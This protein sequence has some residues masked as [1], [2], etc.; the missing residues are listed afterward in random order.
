MFERD[1]ENS[2]EVVLKS[3]KLRSVE[4]RRTPR[5]EEWRTRGRSTRRA[6]AAGAIRMGRTLGAAMTKR[7]EVGAAEAYNL[8]WSSLI[9]LGMGLL[10]LKCPRGSPALWRAGGVVRR[11]RA[12]S[13]P[14]GFTGGKPAKLLRR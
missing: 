14:G 11:R 7:R 9:F 4:R 1:L 13:R 12:C 8:F 6:A 3:R 10:A 2:T 5:I